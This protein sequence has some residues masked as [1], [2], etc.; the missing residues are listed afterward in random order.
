MQALR[1]HH[2]IQRTFGQMYAQAVPDRIVTVEDIDIR[3][4]VRSNP[5][6]LT[7]FATAHVKVPVVAK[8]PALFRVQ[9]PQQQHQS[10]APGSAFAPYHLLPLPV[11]FAH[12]LAPPFFVVHAG[13]NQLPP[14][15]ELAPGCH[16]PDHT[17]RND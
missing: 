8:L 13:G 12:A 6:A 2:V 17:W 5:I 11:V 9:L 10:P 3:D 1:G 15:Q 7:A 4:Q 14:V 16:S